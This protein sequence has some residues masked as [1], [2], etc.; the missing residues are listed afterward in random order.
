MYVSKTESKVRTI[1][2]LDLCWRKERTTSSQHQQQYPATQNVLYCQCVIKHET[3]H[4]W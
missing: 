1:S 2:T 4:Q 3:D